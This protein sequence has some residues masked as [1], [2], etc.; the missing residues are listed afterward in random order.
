M[1]KLTYLFVMIA[2]L[3]LTAVNVNAQ[4]PKSATATVKKEVPSACCKSGDKALGTK[5]GSKE[6]VSDCANK[7]ASMISQNVN[8]KKA[9][10]C[11]SKTESTVSEVKDTKTV[12]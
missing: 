12:N 10:G 2:G 9:A 6:T 7:D 4:D 5:S 1:K 11:K 3:T 8:D